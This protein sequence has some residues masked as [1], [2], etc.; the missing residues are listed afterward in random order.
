VKKELRFEG[1]TTMKCIELY[2]VSMGF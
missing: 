2:D 1:L